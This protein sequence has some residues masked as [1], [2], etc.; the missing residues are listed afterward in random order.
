MTMHGN[1]PRD[2][3][4]TLASMEKEARVASNFNQID[5][6]ERFREYLSNDR[7]FTGYDPDRL[8]ERVM[9]CRSNGAVLDLDDPQLRGLEA[10][11]LDRSGW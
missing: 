6:R 8:I 5:A 2:L 10:R 7:R 3:C 4:A 1:D 11:P 9:L